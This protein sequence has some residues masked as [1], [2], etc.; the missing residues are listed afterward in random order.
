MTSDFHKTILK[1]KLQKSENLILQK[2]YVIW[3]T[4]LKELTNENL[5][6]KIIPYFMSTHLIIY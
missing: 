4:L 3:E 5:S 6:V 1:Q 2:F